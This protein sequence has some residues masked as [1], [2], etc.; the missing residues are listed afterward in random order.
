MSN[1]WPRF[2]RRPVPA[3]RKL[4]PVPPTEGPTDQSLRRQREWERRI[5]ANRADQVKRAETWRNGLSAFLTLILSAL[6]VGG[7][8][9]I[10]GL[11][12]PW[13]ALIAGLIAVG[14]LLAVM[15]LWLT[16]TAQVGGRYAFVTR[17]GAD[18]D[19]EPEIVDAQAAGR[20][21]RLLDRARALVAAGFVLLAAGTIAS[22]V[23]PAAVPDPPGYLVV[24]RTDSQDRPCGKLLSANDSLIRLQVE[25]ERLPQEILFTNVKNFKLVAACP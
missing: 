2:R 11:A 17:T 4:K 8:D 5:A 22:W 12:E 9:A 1:W 21:A 23:A 10:G 20:I 6:V 15:G 16:L 7:R 14:L 25:G 24:Q 18:P 13:K 3:A 19:S